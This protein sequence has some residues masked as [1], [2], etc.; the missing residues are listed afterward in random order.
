MRCDLAARMKR[1]AIRVE[2]ISIYLERRRKGPIYPVIVAGETVYVSGL[3]PFD[4]ETGEIKNVPFLRQSELALEQMR[5]CLE[6]A[7]RPNSGLDGSAAV[8]Q[9]QCPT[10]APRQS[11]HSICRR[12]REA[13]A[14]W[15]CRSVGCG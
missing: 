11:F 4:P 15:L 2:P 12:W 14:R 1:T 13:M 5:C 10:N 9:H 6:A 8:R 3:P 7:G